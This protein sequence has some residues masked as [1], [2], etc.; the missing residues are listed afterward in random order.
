MQDIQE[1]TFIF[2]QTF[3]LYVED[4]ARIHIDSVVLLDVFCKA[5]FVL[6]FDLHEFASCF[7]IIRVQFELCNLRQVRDP[8]VADLVCEPVC[9][10]RVPM[11]EETSLCD[12]VCLVVEL[13][14]HHLIEVSKLLRLQNIRMEP[15]NTVYG[16]ASDDR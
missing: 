8:S 2:M 14:R 4:R 5:D 12:T 3:Y 13:L 11:C 16:E 15:C 6:V 1:L 9:Q 7:L 10:K